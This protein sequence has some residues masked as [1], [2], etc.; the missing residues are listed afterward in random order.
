MHIL[1]SLEYISFEGV[2][3]GGDDIDDY[4]RLGTNNAISKELIHKRFVR[5]ISPFEGEEIA[6]RPSFLFNLSRLP[7]KKCTELVGRGYTRNFLARSQIFLLALWLIRDNSGNSG[8][9]FFCV[10]DDDGEE[11]CM[12]ERHSAYYFTSECTLAAA[13]FTRPE[14]DQAIVFVKQLDGIIPKVF[15]ALEAGR[16]TGLLHASR[17]TR[18]L[19]FLQAARS[20]DDPAVKSVF[21]CICF[22][23][24]FSTDTSGVSHRV[25]ERAAVFLGTNGT[26]RRATYKDIHDLYGYRS[27]VVHGHPLKEKEEGKLR[28]LVVLGDCYLRSTILKILGNDSLL[29]LF[30]QNNVDEVREYFLDEL[31]PTT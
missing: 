22:E 26:E 20:A 23:S 18:C 12:S 15:R 1:Q 9:A 25:A 17:I 14:L 16:P 3:N 30:E 13:T 7:E 27:T 6:N 19:Y 29:A 2:L 24:L 4:L 10:H 11:H 5:A 31:F 8:T 28:A 21:Y